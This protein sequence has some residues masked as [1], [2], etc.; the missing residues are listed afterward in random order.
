MNI[1][2]IHRFDVRLTRVLELEAQNVIV[3]QPAGDIVI[4]GGSYV[5]AKSPRANNLEI[6]LSLGFQAFALIITFVIL[7]SRRNYVVVGIARQSVKIPS[8]REKRN[9]SPNTRR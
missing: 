8:G 9:P 1:R 4:L 3:I 2:R 5:V 6:H 7:L